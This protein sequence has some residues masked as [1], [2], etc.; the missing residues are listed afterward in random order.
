M[1]RRAPA[2]PVPPPRWRYPVNRLLVSL[3]L[4]CLLSTISCGD[5]FVRGAI[6][7]GAQSAGG[8]I[9][10]VQFSA[11]NGSGVSVTIITLTGD[12][13]ANTLSFCG[14]QRTLFPLDKQVQVRFT[15]GQPCAT[16]LTVTLV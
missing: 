3:L 7:L 1:E 6:N 14:D 16:V 10:I 2:E 11:D 15:A 5:I 9:S 12:R 8:T 13:V 4:A